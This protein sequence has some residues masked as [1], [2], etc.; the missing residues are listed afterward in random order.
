MHVPE[1]PAGGGG[2]RPPR[3]GVAVAVDR[4]APVPLGTVVGRM[5]AGTGWLACWLGQAICG[6]TQMLPNTENACAQVQMQ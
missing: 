6:Q 4:R 5:S 1:L 2:R 3:A